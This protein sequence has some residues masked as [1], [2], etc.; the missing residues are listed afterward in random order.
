MTVIETPQ[1]GNPWAAVNF[2][3]LQP[4]N[5]VSDPWAIQ[6]WKVQCNRP[7]ALDVAF[8]RSRAPARPI[9][10]SARKGEMR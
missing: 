6:A 3:N 7:T 10:S 4:L 9:H 5:V 2:E 8:P 1:D